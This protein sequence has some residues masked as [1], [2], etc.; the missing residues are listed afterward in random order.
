M[1]ERDKYIISGGREGKKRLDVLG[2]IL[3]PY[4]K[5]L[6]EA[7]G[8]IKGKKFLDLGCGGGTVSLMAAGMVGPEGNVT[9]IDFDSDIIELAKKDAEEKGLDN[10]SFRSMDAYDLDDEDAFDIVYSRF[11]LSHLQQPAIVLNK[12]HR[13]VKRGGKI[14]IEDI[15]FSGHFSYPRCEA[16]ELYQHYF[17]TAAKNNGQDANI[18]LSL[19]GMFQSGNIRDVKFNVIQPSFNEGKGKWMAYF[20]FDKIKET[21][22]RQS[23]LGEDESNRVLDELKVFTMDNNTILSLPRIFRVW[24]VKGKE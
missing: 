1:A 3:N 11:L 9:A 15:D 22:K 18:G 21:L 5:K 23:L 24:G 14:I 17:V 4:T 6:L 8:S 13:S 10:I 2:K 19:F 16:F 20:T 12:L 7:D